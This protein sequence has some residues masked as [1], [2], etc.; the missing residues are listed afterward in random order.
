M[1]A[2]TQ[3]NQ[4]ALPV[5]HRIDDY[6][7]TSVLG[8][9][10]F[11]ITYKAEDE[12]L[13]R[14]VAIKEYLPQ[15]FAYRDGAGTVRPRGDGDRQLFEWGL[16]RFVDEG[17]ALAMFR[18]SNIASVIRYIKQN[19]TA[20]LVMEFEEGMDLEHWLEGRDPPSEERL[21]QGIL[22]PVLE[23][24]ARV[25]DKGLLHRDIKPDNIFIRRDGTPVLIDFGASRPHGPEAASRLTSIISAGYSPFEQYGSGD[26]QGPWSDL[27]AMAGTM[28]RAISGNPPTDAI[29]RQQGAPLKPAMEVGAGR[30]G[31]RL[32][33]A[34]D[35]ALS[36]DIA[37]RPQDAREFLEDLGF[38]PPPRPAE[39]DATVIQ[40][41]APAQETA[42]PRRWVPL[43]GVAVLS[44]AAA[45]IGL[46]YWGVLTPQGAT[47]RE[48][49][50]PISESSAPQGPAAGPDARP[51]D[52]PE[53]DPAVA[54]SDGT[55]V[56][57][58]DAVDPAPAPV[59]EAPVQ[60]VA[61]VPA[62]EAADTVDPLD[63]ERIL[64]G[65]ALSRN[66]QTFRRDQI[67]GAML[68]Y[69][70]IKTRFDDCRATSCSSL[71]SLLS[72]LKAAAAPQ[73]WRR[74]EAEGSITIQNPR[75]LDNEAC[76]YLLDV[77]E[78]ITV[79]GTTREQVRTY[80]TSNGFDRQVQR[81]D[82]VT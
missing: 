39:A 28:Y 5:G 30:Y 14:F 51:A 67:A 37:E 12:T 42:R 25:H 13:R 29:A 45:A 61:D 56:E 19:G 78:S 26:R 81:A 47:G 7:I 33:Q 11:G 71:P 20:Y 54:G 80:C 44:V 49:A 27:Y 1:T 31:K 9:G 40:R 66:V 32:L 62:E 17:R 10:G 69:T 63:E 2:E 18:H 55:D 6:R 53:T 24:L 75:R 22:V 60:P 74:G 3:V 72:E 76:P 35:R 57:P 21:V 65:M 82:E 52:T 36:M 16:G 77:Q 8:Q 4:L 59:D 58:A 23:G 38:E 41:R 46:Y 48:A 15:Q 70:S 43:L 79:A 34:L 73:L 68:Q 50:E 64:D